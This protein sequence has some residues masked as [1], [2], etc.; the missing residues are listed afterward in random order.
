MASPREVVVTGL[1]LAS[2]L[3]L[4]REAFWQSLIDRR[5]GIFPLTRFNREPF[6]VRMGGQV[7][8]FDAKLYVT[9]RK[10]L[11]VMSRE[12]QLGFAA[13]QLALED[14]RVAA[15]TVDADRF[16]VVFGADMMYSEGAEVDAA[17]LRCLVD[18]KFDF[19]RWG[20][21]GMQE[22]YPLWL[23]K[24]LPN[25]PAC[26]VA[27]AHDARG[28]NNSIL[29]GEASSLLAMSEGMRT[30]EMDRADLMIV[31]G[32]SCP[33]HARNWVFRDPGQ[34][35]RR[36]E[37]PDRAVRPFDADRDGEVLGEGAG[38]IVLESRGHAEA[39]GA[40]P[41]A[42]LVSYASTFG[43]PCSG[44]PNVEAIRNAIRLA[45]DKPGIAASEI[46]HVN[47]N[48]SG[49]R[50]GDRVEA[51]AI[52]DLLGDVPVT[53]PKSFFGNLMAATG[54]LEAAVSLLAFQNGL[55]PITL[56]HE[57]RDPECPVN[58]VVGEPRPSTRPYALLLN[59]SPTGQCVAV[60]LGRE[61]TT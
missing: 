52:A 28:P 58:V 45:L 51:Q 10:S 49:T 31:G 18:G 16:G 19:S 7:R 43:C 4:T 27:I 55:I 34:F 39:R 60:V 21:A 53:A 23:L 1:G 14:A 57:R 12:I 6:P 35:S 56:N 20:E 9:P 8:D 48:G 38:A 3:G 36:Y 42:R 54:T 46:D 30:I 47:A 13:A 50:H 5:S 41:M 59:Q 44:A 26:H 37:E 15:G 61:P 22:I 29:L 40:R 2:P 32:T 24:Y 11:K 25:M 17:F 33:T